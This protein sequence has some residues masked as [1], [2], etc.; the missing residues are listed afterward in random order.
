[1][2]SISVR[3]E[4]EVT[5]E[6]VNVDAKPY[7]PVNDVKTITVAVVV[8]AQFANDMTFAC[9]EHVLDWVRNEASKIGFDIVILRFDNGSSRRKAF[10]VLNCERGGKYVGTNQ[11]L[12]HDDTGSRK[13][14]CP[15]KLRVTCRIDGLWRIS[16]ICEIHNHALETNL[17][18]HL[19]ACRLSHEEKDVISELS[20]IK[21][22]PRNILADL[23]RKTPDSVSHIKQVYNERYNLK[24][25]KMGPRSEMQHL[26]KLL[27]DNQ[28]VSSF[29]TYED[30]VTLKLAVGTKERKDDNGNIVKA[31]VVEDKIM[32]AWREILDAHSEELYTEKVVQF[33]TVSD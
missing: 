5:L 20:I 23:K 15:L 22:A 7:E 27:G 24:V 9:H 17:H 8:R 14:A 4:K 16:V 2:R 13:C 26:L 12:K 29:R 25:M 19:S 3:T 21:V 30:K 31:G 32:A 28:Y 18:G 10:V 1:M 6:E 33:R 11:V